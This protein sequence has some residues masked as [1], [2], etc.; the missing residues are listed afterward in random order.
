MTATLYFLS[1][2]FGNIFGACINPPINVSVGASTCLYGILACLL[3]YMIINWN[4][5]RILG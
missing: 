2:I 1:G 5:L 3:S 4:G